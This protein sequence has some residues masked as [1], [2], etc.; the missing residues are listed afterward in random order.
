MDEESKYDSSAWTSRDDLFFDAGVG[1][2][3][4]EELQ[5]ERM[6]PQ[7]R[8]HAVNV[9]QSGVGEPGVM[10]LDPPVE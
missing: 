6:V 1:P 4:A 3:A 8:W 9:Q 5:V 10:R 2:L 7:A